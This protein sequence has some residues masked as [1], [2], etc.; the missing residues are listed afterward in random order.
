MTDE[1]QPDPLTEAIEKRRRDQRAQEYGATANVT[2]TLRVKCASH[3]AGNATAQEIQEIGGKETLFAIT[4]ALQ[5]AGVSFEIIGSP[6]I[7][8]ITW[9]RSAK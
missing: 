2:L 6:R 5:T 9:D 3:W 7:G 8:L 1:N 4:N